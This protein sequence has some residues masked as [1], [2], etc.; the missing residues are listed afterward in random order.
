MRAMPNIIAI[1]GV[2]VVSLP[3]SNGLTCGEW[4]S[5]AAHGLGLDCGSGLEKQFGGGGISR[6]STLVKGWI[7]FRNWCTLVQL[8]RFAYTTYAKTLIELRT[9]ARGGDDGDPAAFL[10]KMQTLDDM[11]TDFVP[12]LTETY[13]MVYE[14]QYIYRP[15]NVTDPFPEPNHTSMPTTRRRRRCPKRR[16]G[17]RQQQGGILPIFVLLVPALAAAGKAAAL[18]ALGGAAGYAAK[19]GLAAATR[20]RR[21]FWNSRCRS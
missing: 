4:I 15:I 14:A 17:R 2:G 1:G 13:R 8:S 20:R 21:N 19:R 3:I 10:V 9:W 5:P 18:V 16:Q 11:V 12:P 6:L 7:E